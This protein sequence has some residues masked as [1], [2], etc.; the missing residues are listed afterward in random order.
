MGARKEF[1]ERAARMENVVVTYGKNYR[2]NYEGSEEYRI[3]RASGREDMENELFDT[4][5]FFPAFYA[6]LA[7]QGRQDYI[8][9]FLRDES[10]L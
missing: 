7:R 6:S 5:D 1:Q 3:I 8:P 10:F 9:V 4:G 2:K